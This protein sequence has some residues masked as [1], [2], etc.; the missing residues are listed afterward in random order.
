MKRPVSAEA[1]GRE[2]GLFPPQNAVVLILC[3]D[4]RHCTVM[5]I[6]PMR[7]LALE[8][9]ACQFLSSKYISNKYSNCKMM[10]TDMRYRV[11]CLPFPVYSRQVRVVVEKVY[12][13]VCWC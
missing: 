2:W 8:F 12:F 7:R 1:V 5:N 11:V 13:F 9:S 6:S 10:I 3:I 4:V